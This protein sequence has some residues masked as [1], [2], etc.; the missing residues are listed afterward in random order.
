M[1]YELRD[2]KYKIA[3][4]PTDDS[5]VQPC[6]VVWLYGTDLHRTLI[7]LG[8]LLG[9]CTGWFLR[10]KCCTVPSSTSIGLISKLKLQGHHS[11]NKVITSYQFQ[12]KC[13]LDAETGFLLLSWWC[14][15]KTKYESEAVLHFI[16]TDRSSLFST[17]LKSCRI[18][19]LRCAR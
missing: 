19:P 16:R 14:P 9:I 18:V 1:S 15:F 4:S 3:F 11:Q 6:T 8:W 5:T 17:T 7:E 12:C 10:F 2:L 13:C